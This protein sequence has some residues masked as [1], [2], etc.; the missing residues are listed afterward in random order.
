MFK[1]ALFAAVTS[2]LCNLGIGA[3]HVIQD[4]KIEYEAV[5]LANIFD[6]ETVE[7]TIKVITKYKHTC[8]MLNV[9]CFNISVC[10]RA[11]EG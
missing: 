9:F 10:D 4:F 2:I 3:P 11:K 5:V 7:S 6:R 1:F 8:F